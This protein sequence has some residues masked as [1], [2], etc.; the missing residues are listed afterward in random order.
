MLAPH[1]AHISAVQ[2]NVP[3]IQRT[4]EYVYPTKTF[5]GDM[6]IKLG[7]KTFELHN[8]RAETDDLCGYMY[9]NLKLRL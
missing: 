5:L 9:Q 3:E 1:R 7:D 8:T 2:F 6:T 4:P